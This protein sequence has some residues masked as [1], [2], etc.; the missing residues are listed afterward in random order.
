[1]ITRA[2]VKITILYKGEAMAAVYVKQDLTVSKDNE[3]LL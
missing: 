1:M 3:V 2:L